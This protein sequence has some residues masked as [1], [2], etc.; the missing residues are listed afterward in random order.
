MAAHFT[1]LD[2]R[3]YDRDRF[4]SFSTTESQ[5]M[6]ASRL[7]FV[8]I[9][10]IF[11]LFPSS[12]PIPQATCPSQPSPIF[13]CSIHASSKLHSYHV[14]LHAPEKEQTGDTAVGYRHACFCFPHI[15]V[16]NA[17]RVLSPLFSVCVDCRVVAIRQ[18][19]YVP[20]SRLPVAARARC[21][22]SPDS[23]CPSPGRGLSTR[24]QPRQRTD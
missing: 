24:Q 14:V 19:Q 8:Q 17:K 11:I 9:S 7:D 16:L 10:C 18:A 3:D 23:S 13:D 1:H 22:R 12:I 6:N 5:I 21:Q 15:S 2:A 4:L 20:L